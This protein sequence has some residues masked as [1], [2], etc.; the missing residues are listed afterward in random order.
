MIRT[1]CNLT[2]YVSEIQDQM[3]QR[4]TK[5]SHTHYDVKQQERNTFSMNLR[6]KD[7]TQRI[8]WFDPKIYVHCCIIDEQTQKLQE[9]K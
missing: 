4:T 3:S 7:R 9:R 2:L 5:I 6:M 8:K 1:G